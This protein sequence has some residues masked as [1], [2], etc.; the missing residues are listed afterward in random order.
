MVWCA[1]LR[2]RSNYVQQQITLS[3]LDG[4]QPIAEVAGGV[5]GAGG[6][7]VDRGVWLRPFRDLIYAMPPYVIDAEDLATVTSAMCDAARVAV[8][9]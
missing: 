7:A 2:N 9:R 3:A 8:L 4:D 6:A 1:I 5:D